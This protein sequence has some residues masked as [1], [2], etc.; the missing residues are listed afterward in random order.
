V[1]R[2]L[3]FEKAQK[4]S[5]IF[6]SVYDD[7]KYFEFSEGARLILPPSLPERTIICAVILNKSFLALLLLKWEKEEA[8]VCP[9]EERYWLSELVKNELIDKKVHVPYYSCHA[10]SEEPECEAHFRFIR[11]G[12]HIDLA[13]ITPEEQERYRKQLEANLQKT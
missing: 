4:A 11:R 6:I 13:V 7:D 8:W 12:P 10:D 5:D 9:Q 3:E 2:N 1:P